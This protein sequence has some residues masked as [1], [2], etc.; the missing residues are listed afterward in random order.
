MSG[1]GVTA[2]HS[3][4]LGKACVQRRPCLLVLAPNAHLPSSSTHTGTSCPRTALLNL[5]NMALCVRSHHQQPG[6]DGARRRDRLAAAAARQAGTAVQGRRRRRR[7]HGWGRARQGTQ[8]GPDMHAAAQPQ[9]GRHGAETGRPHHSSV[10]Q[11]Q[12]LRTR[13]GQMI[14]IADMALRPPKA[15]QGPHHLGESWGDEPQ[16]KAQRQAG[17]VQCGCGPR[18]AKAHMQSLST[19]F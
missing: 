8:P 10:C 14:C 3:A 2:G 18:P 15:R 6:R 1:R 4:C 7:R 9:R 5:C 16:G 11:K 19:C 13:S 12:V 17:G